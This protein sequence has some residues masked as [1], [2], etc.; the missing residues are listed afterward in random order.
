MEPEK[1]AGY[2]H[3]AEKYV[4]PLIKKIG[5]GPCAA[6]CLL[7]QYTQILA[8]EENR[9]TLE[10]GL[11]IANTVLA[12]WQ[13]GYYVPSPAYYTLDETLADLQK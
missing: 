4:L 6:Q 5:L 9:L 12:L 2:I 10:S 1:L 8:T 3:Q 11:A 7:A 13:E